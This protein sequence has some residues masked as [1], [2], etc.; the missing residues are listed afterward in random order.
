MSSLSHIGKLMLSIAISVL[1]ISCSYQQDKTE[2]KATEPGTLLEYT[3]IETLGTDKINWTINEG[4]NL[5]M[6]NGTMKASDFRDSLAKPKHAVKLYKVAYSS[7][8][9]EKND[10][11][12]TSYG[13]IAIPENVQPNA[14]MVSYQHGTI[15]DHSWT[16]SNPA[17]SMET[18]LMIAQ[19]ASQ[20]YIVIAPDYF[21]TS[22]ESKLPN[23]Y[24]VAQSTAQACLDLYRASLQI[25]KKEKIKPGKLFINGWSQGG[26]STLAFL[27]ALELNNI[28]V[29][30]VVTASGPADPLLFLT[31]SLNNPS[32]Y[33]PPFGIG[34]TSNMILSYDSYYNLNSYLDSSIYPEYAPF[35]HKLYRFEIGYEEFAKNVPVKMDS[36]FLP[37]FYEDSRAV[38]KPFWKTLENNAAYKWKMTTPLRCFYSYR[39]E[40]IPWQVSR[41]AADYQRAL[42]HPNAEAID[43]G[44][45]ADHRSVY[46]YSLVYAKKW[47]DGMAQTDQHQ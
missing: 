39:D 38:S 23:S 8:I 16:P 4:L 47:F 37:T 14:P 44:A 9:P 40:A 25:A 28:P 35:A 19:F 27:H 12:V 22:K 33:A 20:G 41:I 3:L 45:N 30:G 5:F 32:P 31:Q 26:Y 36:V 29:T 10:S 21:G 34:A 6:T 43:A 13:L 7:V 15:F 46:L 24:F 17:G 2:T 18:Q 1:V 11:A 42:G